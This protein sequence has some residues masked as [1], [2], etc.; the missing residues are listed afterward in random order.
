MTK[1]DL[2]SDGIRR[3]WLLSG[4]A[5]M[6]V[7]FG[8]LSPAGIAIASADNKP[9]LRSVVIPVE[10]MS[11]VACAAS[12]KKAL[13][14]LDGVASVQVSLEKRA[15]TVTY[16]AGQVSPE[17]MVGAINKLGYRAGIPKDIE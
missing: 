7:L 10:G 8:A 4:L 15:A 12:V 9:A 2:C 16:A 5:A 13:K 6:V 11:C 14:S 1:S 17:L 3:R